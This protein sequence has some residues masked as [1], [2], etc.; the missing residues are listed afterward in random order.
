VSQIFTNIFIYEMFAVSG[1]NKRR[2][3]HPFSL[4]NCV[5]NVAKKLGM[6]YK[7]N[8][9]VV[10][11]A[12]AVRIPHLITLRLPPSNAETRIITDIEQGCLIHFLK[13]GD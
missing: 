6:R 3:K 8:S 4:L 13:S 7:V 9:D 10:A 2:I 11:M 1:W 12:L 5:R